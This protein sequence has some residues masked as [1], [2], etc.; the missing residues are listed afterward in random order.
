MINSECL[1]L[2]SLSHDDLRQ[3]TA[4]LQTEIHNYIHDYKKKYEDSKAS[5]RDNIAADKNTINTIKLTIEK[6]EEALYKATEKIL[7]QILPTSFAIVKE[8]ARRFTEND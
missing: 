8:T 7:L 3:E 4:K 1:R 5:L 2:Q 6:N